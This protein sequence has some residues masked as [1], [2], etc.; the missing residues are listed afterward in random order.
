MQTKQLFRLIVLFYVAIVADNAIL[1]RRVK[2]P[3]V[4]NNFIVVDNLPVEEFS[5]FDDEK[6]VFKSWIP[7]AQPLTRNPT[8][9]IETLNDMHRDPLNL[10]D[11]L[12]TD[13]ESETRHHPLDHNKLAP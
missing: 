12:H 6:D 11:W 10:D 3:I 4:P 2:D 7:K 9:K 5:S 1:P 13:W 8:I